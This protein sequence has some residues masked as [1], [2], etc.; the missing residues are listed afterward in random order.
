MSDSHEIY[1]EVWLFCLDTHQW[2]RVKLHPK[3]MEEQVKRA[4]HTTFVVDRS[5]A[6]AKLELYIVGGMTSKNGKFVRCSL[7]EL[8]C[9][10][11][12]EIPS[13]A[14]PH[15]KSIDLPEMSRG[16]S[17]VSASNIHNTDHRWDIMA[18]GFST[19]KKDDL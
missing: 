7:T 16:V 13:E 14:K 18:F 19:G 15:K 4:G 11:F 10:D 12:S 8:I 2:T 6:G 9:L 17:M 1:E 3:G 5:K